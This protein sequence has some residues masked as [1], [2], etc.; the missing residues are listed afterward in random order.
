ML[1]QCNPCPKIKKMSKIKIIVTDDHQI[2]RDGISALLLKYP[3]IEIIAEFSNGEELINA[4]ENLN[5]DIVII[6]I[7]MPK[8]T[9]LEAS[10][11]IIKKYPKIG[12][13]IFSS[14]SEG[15]NVIKAFEL[16]V[17]GI[18][19]KSTLREE[20]AEAI[21]AVYEGKEFVSKYIPYSTFFNHAKQS[22]SEN[23]ISDVSDKLSK[24]EIELTKYVA[25][26]LSNQEIADRLYIS[27]RTV[28]KHKSNI[29]LKLDLKSVVD[30][31]KFAIKN[32]II[33]L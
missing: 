14:H 22:K 1:N 27:L 12:I 9:G 32:K 21:Y 33:D 23:E 8:M 11:I 25:E 16:G 29:L 18:L 31:V 19:P 30:L 4:L 28:E 7:A 13:I 6:D 17:K 5:P 2:V 3:E 10:E 20:L 24:R 26:G 15:E